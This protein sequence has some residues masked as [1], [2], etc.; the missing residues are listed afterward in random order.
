MKKL[1]S[2]AIVVPIFKDSFNNYEKFSFYHNAKVLENRE[3]YLLGPQRLERHIH[4]LS[5][6]IK[7][8]RCAIVNDKFFDGTL[9]GNTALMRSETL[10]QTFHRYK[11]IL[12]CHF[13]AIIFE[14]QLDYWT[15][16]NFDFIGAPLFYKSDGTLDYLRIGGNGGFCLRNVNAHLNVIERSK[17]LFSV[18]K[19]IWS[20]N[21]TVKNRFIQYLKYFK[22]NY[23]QLQLR[24]KLYEDSYWSELI[25]NVFNDY[26][27]ADFEYAKSFA[28]ETNIRLL[29]QVNDEKC[30]MG[31]H[32]WWK[33]D[34]EFCKTLILNKFPNVTIPKVKD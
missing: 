6:T 8:G 9:R 34:E 32:A 20:A 3:I 29:F 19:I 31:I 33:Y 25:P 18:F 26:K 27:V 22:F 4:A 30:P 7:N 23:V 17:P 10:Y 28:F 11:Y 21:K 12:I 13:D 1:P 16:L 2:V 14:D 5:K 24:S 15:S